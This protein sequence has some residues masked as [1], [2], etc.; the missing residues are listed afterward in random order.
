MKQKNNPWYY[1]LNGVLV[2]KRKP[3]MPGEIVCVDMSLYYKLVTVHQVYIGGFHDA[4]K[5]YY[6]WDNVVPVFSLMAERDDLKRD[7]DHISEQRKRLIKDLEVCIQMIA[8]VH[9]NDSYAMY[10]EGQKD[11]LKA[12]LDKV[13]IGY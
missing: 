11:A 2:K 6:D 7:L 12:I 3:A 5:N 9:N 1:Y 4:Q 8:P 10:C 13:K